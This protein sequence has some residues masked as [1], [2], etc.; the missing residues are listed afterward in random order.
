MRIL[1][2]SMVLV[3]AGVWAWEMLTITRP[4]AH[5]L[6][7]ARQEL[8]TLSGMLAITLMSLAMFLASRP[9]WLEGVLGGMDRVFRTHKWAGILAAGFALAHWLIEMADDILKSLVGRAGR[10]PEDKFSGFLEILR[11]LAEDAG[12]WAIYGLL[13]MVVLSLWQRFP[14]RPWRFLHRAMP[15]LYLVLAFHA[16]LLAP[17]AYWQQ[18]VGVLLAVLL[19]AGSYGAARS[20]L[21]TIGRARRVSGQIVSVE[22]AGD[23][24]TVDCRLSHA[25]PGHRPGQFAF[26]SFDER[27]GAH[28]FTI[29]S[30][31]HGDRVLRFQIKA[32][33]DYTGGLAERLRLGLPVL[34]EGP[35]GRFDLARCRPQ[36]RQVW[37]AGGVGIT[38]FLAWLEALQTD[39]ARQLPADLHYCT[40]NAG[41]DAFVARLESLCRGLSGV[42]LQVH[43]ASVGARLDATMLGELRAAE[44]WFCGPLGLAD[45]LR[46]GLLA[47]GVR[48]LFHQ[49]AFALR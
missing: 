20:L 24:L 42:R 9:V 26:V 19:V 44:I 7:L 17:R 47:M 25:W 15:V 14:Y 3:V 28:P 6:W 39:P 30:A 13:F 48:P 8:L 27:E 31:D 21:G 29:A 16:A 10:V 4:V 37:I 35:Y 36:L 43:D 11:E 32:L 34:L 1:L 5:P 41:N 2:A 40:R 22:Q 38:P 33:G 12:E 23:V 18:P 46:S 45:A 49:E